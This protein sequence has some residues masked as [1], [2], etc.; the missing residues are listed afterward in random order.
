M[1]ESQNGSHHLLASELYA[2][3]QGTN[4]KGPTEC[5]WCAAPCEKVWTHDDQPNLVIAQ[6]SRLRSLARRPANA[7]I[8]TGCWLFRRKSITVRFLTDGIKDRQDPST[9]SWYVTEQ[10]AW[11]I[12]PQDGLALFKALLNP[13]NRFWLSLITEQ[14]LKNHLQLVISNDLKEFTPEM[15]LF[16]TVN[17]TSHSYSVAELDLFCKGK[18]EASSPGLLALIRIFGKPPVDEQEKRGR[19]RPMKTYKP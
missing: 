12:R 3:S 5:H 17:G 14:N 10:G 16:F 1:T 13:P 6:G 8:C 19:G 7:Y 11:G 15:D 18:Q 2:I 4:C 9:H